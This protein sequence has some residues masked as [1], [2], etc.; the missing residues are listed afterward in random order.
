MQSLETDVVV[1]GAGMGGLVAAVQ[2]LKQTDNV[3]ILEKGDRA[4]GSMYL[5]GGSIWTYDS[6]EKAREAIPHGDRSLQRLVI[7]SLDDDIE[8]LTDVVDL[9]PAPLTDDVPGSGVEFDPPSLTDQLT[10]EI[11]NEGGDI[12]LQTPMTELLGERCNGVNGAC[13]ATADG[14]R[15]R[16]ETDSVILAT[17]GFQGNERLLERYVTDSPEHLWLR[18][19]PWSTGDGLLAA[20]GLGAKTSA[21][22]G[23]FYGHNMVAPPAKFS[24]T[25]LQDASQYYGSYAIALDRRGQRFTDESESLQEETLA[26][27]TARCAGGRAYLTV[28]HD[29]YGKDIGGE[30][31]GEMIERAAGYGGR[32]ARC[33]S[34]DSL[35]TAVADWDLNG[36]RAVE[37]VRHFNRAIRRDESALLEYPRQRNRYPIDE[38]PF[39]VVEVQPGITF[40]VGGLHVDTE[41]RV[42]R[43]NASVS[44]LDT[45]VKT[46]N[47]T[48]GRISGLFAAGVAVGNVNYRRYLG[49]LSLAL[50][51]GRIAGKNAA[52]HGDN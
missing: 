5:S 50:V 15:I 23:C 17:G 30:T 3:I 10:T 29:L 4:G 7:E 20:L 39:Y 34:L 43:R 46:D 18:A 37:T 47:R 42:F 14:S 27:D 52:E 32:V 22:F 51:T 44:T 1:V 19:N 12:R 13:A 16:I 21:G 40:T 41:T 49:G 9:E 8:W 48:N 35:A 11:A 28:D 26:Q 25:E 2:A 38:P 36:S 6:V 31:V 33:D 24:P 45:P